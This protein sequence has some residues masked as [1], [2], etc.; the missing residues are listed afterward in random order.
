MALVVE[1]GSGTEASANT[2]ADVDR[3]KLYLTA[4]GI[5][6]PS[7]AEIIVAAI[8]AMDYI[9]SVEERLQG[10]RVSG[11]QPTPFPRTGVKLFGFEVAEDEI[12]YQLIEAQCQLAADSLSGVDLLPNT[13]SAPIKREKTGPLETEYAIAAGDLS[14][15]HLAKADAMLRPF[16]R[17]GGFGLKV[18][19]G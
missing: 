10:S 18:T 2:F 8:E 11:T 5:A 3:I 1:N 6:I 19:R 14:T 15:P 9:R 16:Y 17:Q 12:P 4:R 13:V 7:D